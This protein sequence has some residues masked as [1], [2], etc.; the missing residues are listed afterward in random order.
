MSSSLLIETRM[1]APLPSPMVSEV[2]LRQG[3]ERQVLPRQRADELRLAHGG[4]TIDLGLLGQP[5][6]VLLGQRRQRV[7]AEP[8]VRPSPRPGAG[9]ATLAGAVGSRRSGHGPG[10]HLPLQPVVPPRRPWPGPPPRGARPH[11]SPPS[12]PPAPPGPPSRPARAPAPGPR[13]PASIASAARRWASSARCCDSRVRAAASASARSTILLA[14]AS[15]AIRSL[16]TRCSAAARARFTRS[17]CSRSTSA[18]AACMSF[19]GCRDARPHAVLG[20]LARLLDLP[21]PFLHD[22]GGLLRVVLRLLGEADRL[23]LALAGQLGGTVGVAHQV[24]NRV[25][26]QPGHRVGDGSPASFARRRAVSET[27]RLLSAAVVAAS[28]TWSATVAAPS[29]AGRNILASTHATFAG[30][31][32]KPVVATVGEALRGPSLWPSWRPPDERDGG[33]RDQ[34]AV[35]AVAR[36]ELEPGPMGRPRCRPARDAAA[37]H[38]GGQSYARPAS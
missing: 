4:A 16:S 7:A 30:I 37:T 35:T 8:V 18:T 11:A 17:A 36:Q 6:Q 5:E 3:V 32:R 28:E 24:G 14:A 25:A 20:R 10:P 34:S 27:D 21:L 33:R 1:S 31:S 38:P 29:V 12:Q 13:R 22:P 15:S 2:V 26:A 19:C 23:R 9:R